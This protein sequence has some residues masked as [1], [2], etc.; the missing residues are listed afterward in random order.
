[1]DCAIKLATF[2]F[3]TEIGRLR[4]RKKRLKNSSFFLL[5]SEGAKRPG[6]NAR[7]QGLFPQVI[8]KFSKPGE[9]PYKDLSRRKH[10]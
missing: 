6:R 7:A 4:R 1:M 8:L 2:N 9:G 5:Y 10:V 3:R